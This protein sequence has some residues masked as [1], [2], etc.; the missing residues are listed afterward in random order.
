MVPKFRYES[1]V[2]PFSFFHS[3][4]S[5]NVKIG[6]KRFEPKIL[7][8]FLNSDLYTMLSYGPGKCSYYVN[9]TLLGAF[10]H[11]STLRPVVL[12]HRKWHHLCKGSVT[13]TVKDGIKERT[14]T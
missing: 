2:G 6:E 3:T 8:Y 7:K 12:F 1:K 4:G 11:M 10:F 13:N 9:F 14:F 5:V